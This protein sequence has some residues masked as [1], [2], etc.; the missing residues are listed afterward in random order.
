MGLLVW[1]L[2][3]GQLPY[4]DLAHVYYLTSRGYQSES[5]MAPALRGCWTDKNTE[6]QHSQ[7][8]M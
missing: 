7:F 4:L 3:H 2:L 6:L 1:I 5:D 8:L